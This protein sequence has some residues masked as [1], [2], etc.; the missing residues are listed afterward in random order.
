MKGLEDTPLI[1][2]ILTHLLVADRPHSAT[3]YT[4]P[5]EFVMA[6]LPP[7][8]AQLILSEETSPT[9]RR[10]A[11]RLLATFHTDPA[12][13]CAI[14]H[15]VADAAKHIDG[16]LDQLELLEATSEEIREA[17]EAMLLD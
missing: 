14:A 10:W 11:T 17:R 7:F 4:R 1:L 16:T 5:E 6:E 12:F 8:L 2:G 15:R 9:I 13:A 3:I